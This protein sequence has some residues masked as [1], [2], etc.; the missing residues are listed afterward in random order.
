MPPKRRKRI[1]N[2]LICK[3]SIV[4]EDSKKGYQGL[5]NPEPVVEIPPDD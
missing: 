3:G 2:N 1:V 4:S 5:A